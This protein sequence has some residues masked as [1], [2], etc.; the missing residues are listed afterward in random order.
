MVP[1]PLRAHRRSTTPARASARRC[2][3][4][5]PR[6]ATCPRSG[7]A[8]RCSR[9]ARSGSRS[10][11]RPTTS[12][13]VGVHDFDGALTS[14][15]TAHPKIDPQTGRMH[16]FGYGFTPPYLTYHV[17]EPDG[18]L[19]HHE[20]V[21]IPRSTMMHDFAI[22]DQDVVFWDLP[23]IF[24]LD[25]ATR[26]IAD[27]EL[28]R[29]P[30]PVGSRPPAP[31]SGSCRSAVRRARS[32][33][34]T[35]NRASCSTGSTRTATAR[36]SCSTSAGCRRCSP[37]TSRSAAT[38]SERRW[39]VDTTTGRVQDEVV[40][41][42]RPGELPSRDPRHVGRANRYDYLVAGPRPGRRRRLR[43]RDQARP[44]HRP[45]RGVVARRRGARR[46]VAVRPDRRRRGRRLPAHVHVRRPHRALA[47]RRPRRHRRRRGPVARVALP[48]RVPYG[49][50]GTWV[51]A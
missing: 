43:R 27:P 46:R 29:V 14:A 51:P 3:A 18:T 31:G 24:D 17:T 4:T 28:R 33:G 36:T 20:V 15:F 40:E 12:S 49:F 41:A 30:V 38:L 26:W 9:A 47:P 11:S 5:P 42:D 48:Q 8:A 44:P 16:S 6:R 25:A 10:A 35:S 39:T 19:V 22:T 2:R 45:P 32:A 21:D 37:R 34:T 1:Q 7:T 50:H 23:V 13:T